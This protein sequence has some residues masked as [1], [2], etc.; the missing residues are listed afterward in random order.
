MADSGLEYLIRL[1]YPGDFTHIMDGGSNYKSLR[2]HFLIDS[3]LC[4]YLLEDDITEE[5]LGD[6]ACYI[7]KCSND[8]LGINHKNRVVQD[9]SERIKKKFEKLSAN[10][11]TSAL[12]A[13]YRG[14]ICL[15]KDFIRAE[16]LHDLDLH[17]AIVAKMLLIFAAAGLSQYSKALRLYLEQMTVQEIQY[18]ALVKT[19]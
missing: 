3:A 8:K 13:T 15:I 4:C 1:V 14:F 16:R 11:R 9:V 6:I 18:V 19:F 10:S 7:V 12:W 17:L 2:A 5:D